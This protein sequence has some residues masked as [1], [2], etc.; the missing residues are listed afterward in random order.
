M[1]HRRETQETINPASSEDVFQGELRA[2]L[3]AIV[4]SADDAIIGKTLGGTVTSWN[5]AAKPIFGHGAEEMIGRNILRLSPPERTHQE[6]RII[7]QISKGKPV[8][9]HEI[10]H[11][12]KAG[13]PIHIPVN[14]SPV[15]EGPDRIIGR[16][17]RTLKLDR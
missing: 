7:A 6:E 3:A 12:R 8:E 9:H 16:N 4:D 5:P 2:R 14:V 1:T 11:V 13:R 15:R 17:N 10:V